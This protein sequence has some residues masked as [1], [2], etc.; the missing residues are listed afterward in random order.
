MAYKRSEQASRRRRS[1]I[2]E[3]LNEMI[4]RHGKAA[5][6]LATHHGGWHQYRPDFTH[7]GEELTLPGTDLA[8]HPRSPP[9]PTRGRFC[10]CRHAGAGQGWAPS[11]RSMQRIHTWGCWT[12]CRRDL[13]PNHSRVHFSRR[14]PAEE[15]TFILTMRLK[16]RLPRLSLYQLRPRMAALCRQLT[17]DSKFSSHLEVNQICFTSSKE[18]KHVYSADTMAVG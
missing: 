1:N 3:C 10:A 6:R 14:Y 2:T 11:A 12:G 8:P 16:L 9:V 15:L 18:P 7:C 5:H 17:S 4:D 13:A